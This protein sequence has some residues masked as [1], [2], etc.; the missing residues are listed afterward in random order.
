VY[1]LLQQSSPT[2]SFAAPPVNHEI[3]TLYP[4]GGCARTFLWRS[5]ILEAF[6]IYEYRTEPDEPMALLLRARLCRNPNG[7]SPSAEFIWVGGR[8]N[9]DGGSLATLGGDCEGG[10]EGRMLSP[11][12][13]NSSGI[14]YYSSGDGGGECIVY[15]GNITVEP[16]F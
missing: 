7:G 12:P 4:P 3:E 11:G 1:V 16:V 9:P 2:R 13:C 14:S 5:V 8:D 10:W 15:G 6:P